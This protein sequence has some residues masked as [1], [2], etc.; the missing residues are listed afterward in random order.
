MT[1]LD[2]MRTSSSRCLELNCLEKVLLKGVTLELNVHDSGNE[3]PNMAPIFAHI[4]RLLSVPFLHIFK[5][6]VENY[7]LNN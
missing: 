2:T 6:I 3:R 1:G 4:Y 7:Y 5:R